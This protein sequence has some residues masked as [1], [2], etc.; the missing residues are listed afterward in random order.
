M[1]YVEPIRSAEWVNEFATYLKNKNMRDY[2]MF[3]FG[4]NTGL[5]I[6]DIL[7]FKKRD[8]LGTHIILFEQKT[9]K[10]NRIFI[11]PDLRKILD[12]YIKD[13][14][15]QDYL[16]LSQK[17]TLTGK[18]RPIDRTTA[19]RIL[20]EAA[21]AI[22]YTEPVGTHTL[23]KTF[24][25]NFYKNYKDIGTLMKHYNHDNERIT[26]FYIGIGQDDIDEKI[27]GLYRGVFN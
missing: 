22:G 26:L 10:Q 8:V 25:Y 9:N 18:Q 23:R 21:E 27:A 2:V 1:R 14:K 5:R 16:F 4:I 11:A 7:Q 20:K 17:K 12:K 6:S 3:M 24:G 13:L 15:N 19:Y